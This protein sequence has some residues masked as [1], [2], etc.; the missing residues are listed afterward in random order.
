MRLGES[1]HETAVVGLH[2]TCGFFT[3]FECYSSRAD[4]HGAKHSL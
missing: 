4:S 2:A 1:F 3:K